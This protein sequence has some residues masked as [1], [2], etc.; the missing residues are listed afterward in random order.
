MLGLG[1]SVTSIDSGQIY[2]ELSE[3]GNYADLDVYFDFSTLTGDHGDEVSAA[4]NL[5]QGGSTNNIDSNSGT[6]SL[7]RSTMSRASVAFDGANDVLNMANAYTTSAKSFTVFFI[8][9]RANVGNEYTFVSSTTTTT[10]VP[11]DLIRLTGDGGSIQIGLQTQTPVSMTTA[12]TAN[13]T[14]NYTAVINTPTLYVMRRNASGNVYTFADNNIFI[15]SKGNAAVRAGATLEIGLV[16]GTTEIGASESG[17][18]DLAGNIAEFGIY[19]ADIGNTN[20]EILC[21]QICRK[22]GIVRTS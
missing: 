18:T 17:L 15:A 7:D 8:I 13:S 19:D 20:V 3:L 14:I 21:E 4:T 9:Q 1:T 12:S 11:D 6:P 5:G 10:N 16:G 22:W 2:K